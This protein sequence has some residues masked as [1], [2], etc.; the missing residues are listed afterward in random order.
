MSIK[1]YYKV[2]FIE[3]LIKLNAVGPKTEKIENI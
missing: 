2:A 3:F 1:V